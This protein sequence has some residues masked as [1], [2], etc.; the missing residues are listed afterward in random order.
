AAAAVSQPVPAGATAAAKASP[1]AA[2]AEGLVAITAPVVGKFYSAPA[3]S[4]P[5]YVEVGRQG[6]G[7]A[8]GGVVEGRKGFA[9]VKTETAGTIE[10]IL[11]TNG[12]FV[13]FGQ[14]LFLLRP[15]GR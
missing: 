7:G 12:E 2:A 15:E 3:P 6:G 1:A 8:A 13:E 14:T 5:P 4:D 9:R 11:V 10:K